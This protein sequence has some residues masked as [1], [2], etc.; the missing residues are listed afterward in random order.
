MNRLVNRFFE[1]GYGGM[2]HALESCKK[3]R[4][5]PSNRSEMGLALQEAFSACDAA[6]EAAKVEF[7]Q[8]HVSVGDIAC[9]ITMGNGRPATVAAAY[10]VRFG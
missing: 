6:V 3:V 7:M 2:Q 4:L 10:S 5:D 8:A 1:L 9:S